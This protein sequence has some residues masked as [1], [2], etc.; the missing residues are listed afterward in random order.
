MAYMSES[1]RRHVMWYV[2]EDAK[3]GFLDTDKAYRIKHTFERTAVS[4]KLLAFQVL[5]LD[6]A[7]P[8]GVS[9][10]DL[11]KR[12]DGNL[13]FPTTDMLKQMKESFQK[14]ENVKSY[15]DWFEVKLNHEIWLL[16]NK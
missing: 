10:G 13:G 9:R 8:K 14:L 15:K 3:L 1:W 4:R 7:M 2:K 16:V 12:Y 11:V 6:I 5:F